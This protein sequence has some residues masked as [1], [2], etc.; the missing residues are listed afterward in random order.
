MKSFFSGRLRAFTG[1]ITA[2]DADAVVNAA[3][4][5]LLGGGGVDGAIHRAGGPSILEECEDIRTHRY[6]NGLPPGKS[7][8][9]GAGKLKC[10]YVIHTVGPIWHGGRNGEREILAEAY[11]SSL[12]LASEAGIKSIC[13]PAISTGIYGFPKQ[14]AASIAF[15]T[16]SCFIR[17]NSLPREVNLVFF[18]EEDLNV[19]TEA[20]EKSR[21]SV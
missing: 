9:T 18:S 8:I 20:V 19:F 6:P 13:F 21:L 1:D 5:S 12:Q 11:R 14:I 4:S 7:V 3:N 10:S 16:I 2:I 15:D 17:R